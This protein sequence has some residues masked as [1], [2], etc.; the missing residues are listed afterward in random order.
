[1]GEVTAAGP[2][3]EGGDDEGEPPQ[4][5]DGPGK[6]GANLE[7]EE[8]GDRGE[9]D[10][11]LDG[12]EED[13]LEEGVRERHRNETSCLGVGD[14]RIIPSPASSNAFPLLQPDSA[15]GLARERGR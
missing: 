4:N 14:S 3:G 15:A 1:M 2:A 11:Q 10:E 6:P 12:V 7:A 8:K 9:K 13:E 5:S